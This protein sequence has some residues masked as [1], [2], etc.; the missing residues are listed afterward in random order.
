MKIRGGYVSNSSSSS[1]IFGSKT[2]II[3]GDKILK[4]LAVPENSPIFILC[5]DIVSYFVNAAEYDTKE[6]LENMIYYPEKDKQR[7]KKAIEEYPYV[8]EITIE[9]NNSESP[10]EVVLGDGNILSRENLEKMG[11]VLIDENRE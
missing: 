2:K 8:F 4:V 3:S 1:F 9:K 10:V 5:K 7:I 11:L 6:I